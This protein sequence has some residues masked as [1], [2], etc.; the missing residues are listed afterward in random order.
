MVN[1]KRILRTLLIIVACS[2]GTSAARPSLTQD[3]ERSKGIRSAEIINRPSKLQSSKAT[4]SGK[5][6][7]RV[8]YSS[9]KRYTRSRP[10][11]GMKYVK[12]GVTIWRLQGDGS[13]SLDQVKEEDQ[14]LEQ[15]ETNAP[16]GIGSNVRLG[17]ESLTY[18]GYLYIIDRE[19][20]DDGTYGTARLI[21]PTRKT[22]KGNNFVRVNERVMIPGRPSYFTINQSNTGK[23][24]IAEIL[25]I[26]ISPT[27]LPLPIALT[28]EPMFF[29]DEQFKK[30]EK[31][32]VPAT[33]FEM[34]GGAGDLIDAKTLG[35]VGE[36]TQQ[37]TE[38][39][40]LP[41]TIYRVVIKSGNPML[42]TVP[43]QFK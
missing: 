7:P 4:K 31:W 9:S 43:L 36:E 35:Q 24:Q 40:P 21:F 37:L 42:I 41:Q 22:R 8:T 17:I 25:T 33:E 16:L 3:Q 39:D 12:V 1:S 26:I 10:A 11:R 28:E 19:Q 32:S 30:W 23:T 20:F 15:V 34:E 27:R 6:R 13:K 38:E 18:N 5:P 2:F 29:T 14:T